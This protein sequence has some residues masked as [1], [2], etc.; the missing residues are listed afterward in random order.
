[1]WNLCVLQ[2]LEFPKH[3]QHSLCG[4]VKPWGDGEGSAKKLY[5]KLS[6]CVIDSQSAFSVDSLSKRLNIK[7]CGYLGQT[8]SWGK[9]YNCRAALHWDSSGCHCRPKACWACHRGGGGKSTPPPHSFLY[10][11]YSPILPFCQVC[12]PVLSVNCQGGVTELPERRYC[13]IF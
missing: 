11:F 2:D 8:S 12:G 5:I 3:V 9:G 10:G 13:P 4:G 6:D 1:M 7:K